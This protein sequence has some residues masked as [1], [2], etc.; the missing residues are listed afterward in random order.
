MDEHG[1]AEGW[2]AMLVN[3]LEVLPSAQPEP[4]E[5]AEYYRGK[6]DG[7]KECT[8]RLRLLTAELKDR[9]MDG[10]DANV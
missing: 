3:S 5:D 1:S 9:E 8:A 4:C 7:I 10:G 6:I 2:L